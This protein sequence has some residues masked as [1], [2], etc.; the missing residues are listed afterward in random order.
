MCIKA[1]E[2]DPWPLKYVAENS[3]T[4]GMCKKAV[5][6]GPWVLAYVPDNI[7]TQ[8]ICKKAVEEDRNMLQCITD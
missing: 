5:K 2:V 4:Q 1:L 3:K 7:K 8:K 6:I